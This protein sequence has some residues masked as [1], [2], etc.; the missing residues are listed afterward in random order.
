MSEQRLLAPD[1][2][3]G[4]APVTPSRLARDLRQLGL[5]HGTTVIVHT[6]LSNLGWVPGGAQGVIEALLDVLGESGT[7]V[8]PAHTGHLS[9]PSGWVAPPVPKAW[10]PTIRK[11]MPPYDRALTPTRLMGVVAETFR[12]HPG[13][14]RS[15]HPHVSFAALGPNAERI[16]AEHPL[17]SMFGERSPLARLYELDAHVLLAGVTHA[18][19]T[20]IHLGE[21]R[22]DFV[23]KGRV[24]EAAPMRVDGKRRWVTFEEWRPVDDDF[25]ELGEDFALTGQER[26]GPLGWGE[27]RFMRVTDIVDFAKWWLST[28]RP[29]SLR[30]NQAD[31]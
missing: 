25:A 26:R 19:N 27:G 14:M 15:A 9:D 16:V 24:Q 10:W 17:G 11:E 21:T 1:N 22:A 23:G 20:C 12:R 8:M 30:A 2:V 28:H 29:A 31:I 5:R 13:A 18:N 7:L 6:S 3:A 4:R